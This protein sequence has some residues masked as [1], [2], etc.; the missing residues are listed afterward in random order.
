[1]NID[2]APEHDEDPI[3]VQFVLELELCPD[4]DPLE[5]L[6]AFPEAILDLVEALPGIHKSRLMA[7]IGQMLVDGKVEPNGI[8]SSIQLVGPNHD[9]SD[10]DA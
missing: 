4:H 3:S 7:V 2:C 8:R 1:M 6:D 9:D 10:E 5:Q